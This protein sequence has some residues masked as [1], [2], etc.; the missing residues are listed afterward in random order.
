[1][2]QTHY[3]RDY[4]VFFGIDVDKHSFMFTV[5]N[6]GTM[7]KAKK[8]PSDPEQLSRYV[9]NHFADK[10]VLF[11]YEAGPTGYH[12]YDYL[13][14]QGHECLV[15]SPLSIPRA[16]NHK[17]KNNRIDSLRIVKELKAGKLQSI[18]VP[19]GIYRELRHLVALRENYTHNRKMA[20]QRIKSLLLYTNLS[21]ALKDTAQNWTGSYLRTLQKLPC[22]DA[23]RQRLDMLL[24]DLDYSRKQ[25]LSVLRQLRKFVNDQPELRKYMDCLLSIPGV[26]FIT[27]VTILGRI[28]DPKKLRDV[29][30]LSA[31]V[32]LVPVESSTGDDVNRG[33]I[34]HSGNRVLR[35]LLVEAS[36]S[37]IRKDNE[38]NQFFHRVRSRHHPKIGQRKAIVAVARKL[39]HRIYRVLKEQR[40]YIVH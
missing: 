9:T 11:A 21:A 25:N 14:K 28:G 5:E 39:T 34:T 26:G 36:W 22:S 12:L 33:P 16:M 27:G 18:R 1:M 13:S 23:V 15:V 8:I 31:F 30:E 19:Q 20:K 6:H 24:M 29:R 32:G 7:S 2:T 40:K 37:A 38:L 17:V 3:S 4:E 10:K 35:S